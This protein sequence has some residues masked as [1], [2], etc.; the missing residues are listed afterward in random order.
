M[1]TKNIQYFN[2]YV[3]HGPEML[4]LN[5]LNILNILNIRAMVEEDKE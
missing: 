3:S 5:M 2:Y 1:H 4:I